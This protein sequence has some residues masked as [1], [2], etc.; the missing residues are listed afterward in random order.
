MKTVFYSSMILAFIGAFLHFLSD[1]A[2]QRKLTEALRI[3]I[4]LLLVLTWRDGFVRQTLPS[5]PQISETD[6]SAFAEIAEKTN[7][8]ICIQV[9]NALSEELQADLTERYSFPPVSCTFCLDRESYLPVKIT[10]TYPGEKAISGYAV[11]KYVTE[12][13]HA[14]TEVIFA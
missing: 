11:K 12:K 14:E 4:A 5:L 6:D 3:L 10:V 2:K 1:A 7:E 8:E 9:E 13:Y